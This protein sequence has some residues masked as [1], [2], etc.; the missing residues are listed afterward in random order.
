MQFSVT[1][2]LL[3]ISL[4]VFS[5]STSIAAAPSLITVK[6]PPNLNKGFFMYS[7][8]HR[9]Y[10]Q[11]SGDVADHFFGLDDRANIDMSLSYAPMD[12]LKITGHRRRIEKEYELEVD[13]GAYHTD[14]FSVGV[15]ASAFSFLR[16]GET[17]RDANFFLTASLE[18]PDVF[19]KFSPAVNVAYD[20]Y[21]EDAGFAL[22]A[23]WEVF[24]GYFLLAEYIPS[25]DTLGEDGAYLVGGKIKTFGH[26]FNLFLTN[27]AN[28]G[29]RRLMEGSNGNQPSLGFSITR[30][31]AL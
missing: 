23:S 21:N 25:T 17:D 7:I 5:L 2:K 1:Q 31:I 24:Y 10:S 6:T 16:S 14:R 20:M 8:E 19:H 9:F 28:I 15:G 18:L 27:D 30:L 4:F 3:F 12:K 22:G 13:Y 26:D 29:L 11:V